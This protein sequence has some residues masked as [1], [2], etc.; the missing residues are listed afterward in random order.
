[1]AI[2]IQ[3]DVDTGVAKLFADYLGMDARFE[4]LGCVSVPQVMEPDP[5]DTTLSGNPGEGVGDASRCQRSA[6]WMGEDQGL[7]SK[8]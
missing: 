7:L 6:I 8:G 2:G 4:H 3:G 1:M 5:M